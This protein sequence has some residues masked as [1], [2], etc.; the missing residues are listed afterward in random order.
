MKKIDALDAYRKLEPVVKGRDELLIRLAKDLAKL[1]AKRRTLRAQ[2]REIDRQIR[3]VNRD[4][5]TVKSQR[6]WH[7]SG[8]TSKVFG[9]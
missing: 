3:V 4:I 2:L 1:Q 9:G 6:D 7:E 5:R 8:A